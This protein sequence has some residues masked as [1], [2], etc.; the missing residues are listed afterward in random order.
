MP[1]ASGGD[2]E[3]DLV[4]IRKK[5]KETGTA[6]KRR[7]GSKNSEASKPKKKPV[8]KQPV[9][10]PS[11][12]PAVEEQR[13]ETQAPGL[14]EEKM[15]GTPVVE[16]SSKVPAEV[17]AE[18]STVALEE[19]VEGELKDLKDILLSQHE[20]KAEEEEEQIQL[21]T[22]M[23]A[24]EEYGLNIMD[25]KEIVRPKE[26]TEVPRTPAYIQGIISL[27][28]VIIPIYDVKKRLGLVATEQDP[29]NRIIVVKS[30]EHFFGLLVDSVVQVMDVPL[31]KIDPPPEIV[32]SVEG[33]FLIGIGKVDERLI[34]L[35]N[36]QKVLAVDDDET[37]VLKDG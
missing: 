14:P 29:R 13:T 24:D 28:G 1:W 37:G 11:P 35:M 7:S 16:K 15:E 27:R 18:V 19:A 31:S 10:K 20:E 17:K 6:K 32:G 33:E 36:L 8:K 34:I 23:L 9:Q 26:A 2:K 22:F 3:M 5:A 4:K 25:I 21:L 12:A 30:N